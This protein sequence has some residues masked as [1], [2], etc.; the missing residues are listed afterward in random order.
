MRRII[1]ILFVYLFIQDCFAQGN[2]PDR[3]TI[4]KG[5][6]KAYEKARREHIRKK[7]QEAERMQRQAA[8]QQQINRQA[9]QFQ[10]AAQNIQ[11]INSSNYMSGSQNFQN[12]N[13]RDTQS[14]GAPTRARVRRTQSSQNKQ[15]PRTFQP[16]QR[17]VITHYN[18][19][20]TGT[21]GPSVQYATYKNVK[22]FQPYKPKKPTRKTVVPK[23][24]K[25]EITY[26]NHPGEMW[27]T[28]AS[29]QVA[30]AT[31]QG[32]RS[33]NTSHVGN[34]QSSTGYRSTTGMQTTTRS[35]PQ[36]IQ[37]TNEPAKVAQNSKGNNPSGGVIQ[38]SPNNTNAQQG[39][40]AKTTAP[41]S[42][43]QE[44]ESR[45][46]NNS[47]TSADK[48]QSGGNDNNTDKQSKVNNSNANQVRKGI[49]VSLANGLKKKNSTSTETGGVVLNPFLQCIT[50]KL[51]SQEELECI[52]KLSRVQQRQIEQMLKGK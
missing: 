3:A 52:E 17:N 47:T 30:S 39:N 42:N 15:Y 22:K 8:Q 44:Q 51:N 1:M 35:I 14:N 13:M 24:Q 16:V 25:V 10:Q 12:R 50:G 41:Q 18:M 29:I 28:Q 27:P 2:Y 11:Q 26:P 43:D 19:N 21:G 7:Q 20:N 4:E 38:D 37:P 23:L 6:I 36:P 40:G 34:G 45:T 5:V 33:S 32:T 48:A 46:E 31:S 9:Q 49:K